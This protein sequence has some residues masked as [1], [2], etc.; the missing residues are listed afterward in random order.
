[1]SHIIRDVRQI[2][3]SMK[4]EIGFVTTRITSRLWNLANCVEIQMGFNFYL[5][6]IVTVVVAQGA[7]ETLT[8]S[9]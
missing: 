8:L 7:I 5:T 2:E 1:M 4:Q 6:R 9:I 3:N